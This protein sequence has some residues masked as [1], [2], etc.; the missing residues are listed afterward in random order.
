[1]DTEKDVCMPCYN[2]AAGRRTDNAREHVCRCC[3]PGGTRCRSCDVKNGAC[4]RL[5]LTESGYVKCASCQLQEVTDWCDRLDMQHHFVDAWA[6]SWFR[7]MLRFTSF[8]LN[9]R[10]LGGR[11]I[12]EVRSE[13]AQIQTLTT[14]TLAH[15]C[16]MTVQACSHIK[17]NTE[18]TTLPT[19]VLLRKRVGQ[20]WAARELNSV[21]SRVGDSMH[22]AKKLNFEGASPEGAPELL[23]FRAV[24]RVQYIGPHMNCTG[25]IDSFQSCPHSVFL[26][27]PAALLLAGDQHT[28]VGY[29]PVDMWTC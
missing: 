13:E 24:L 16:D 29:L 20:D 1:M 21:F 12:K 15:I 25:A 4:G 27:T 14:T 18:W 10:F 22:V 2:F 11:S 6:D 3:K 8:K 26:I 5:A 28:G 7:E 17:E 19:F 9:P 23:A